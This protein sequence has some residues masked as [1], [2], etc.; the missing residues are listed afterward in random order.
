MRWNL[1]AGR[2]QILAVHSSLGTSL[3]IFFAITVYSI[4]L[5]ASAD[6][7]DKTDCNG[8][9]LD[10]SAFA[11]PIVR[12]H[13]DPSY[14]ALANPEVRPLGGGEGYGN[15]VPRP[16]TVVRTGDELRAA[17]LAAAHAKSSTIYVDDD[18]EILPLA[19]RARADRVAFAP[20][21]G[22]R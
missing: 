17:L 5:L 13:R 6:T 22:L 8:V 11:E 20:Y 4:A 9:V 2:A 18:A 14:G 10:D 16:A 19:G 12:D 15:I 21:G 3:P 1:F 7:L